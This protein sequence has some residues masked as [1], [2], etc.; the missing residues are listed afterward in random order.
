MKKTGKRVPFPFFSDHSN[1]VSQAMFGIN[2]R[3]TFEIRRMQLDIRP[4]LNPL[5]GSAAA[6]L[7][8]VASGSINIAFASQDATNHDTASMSASYRMYVADNRNLN[9]LTKQHTKDIWVCPMHSKIHQHEPG[10]C[11]ICKMNLVKE[12]S[13]KT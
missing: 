2:H 5:I 10:K 13:V 4:T 9:T 7:F 1:L 12:K 3:S 8:L 11:P 6:L